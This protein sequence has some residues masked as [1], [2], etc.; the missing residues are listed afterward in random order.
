MRDHRLALEEKPGQIKASKEPSWFCINIREEV[1][2][3]K[4]PSSPAVNNSKRLEGPRGRLSLVQKKEWHWATSHIHERQD[5][6]VPRSYRRRI[7]LWMEVRWK[8]KKKERERKKTFAVLLR[9]CAEVERLCIDLADKENREI[10]HMFIS[11]TPWNKQP[12]LRLSLLPTQG[13][14]RRRL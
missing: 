2:K 8:K 13:P 14:A 7:H 12:S 4:G 3:G 6:A 1:R 9:H 11:R 5:P 10:F